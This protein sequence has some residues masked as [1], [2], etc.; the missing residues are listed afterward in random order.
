MGDGILSADSLSLSLCSR[1]GAWLIH[2][3][4]IVLAIV[5]L[6]TIPGMSQDLTWSIVN[7]GYLFV[8]PASSL[9]RCLVVCTLRPLAS[10]N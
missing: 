6:E 7:L 2:V 1:T 10:P 4:L 5:L 9:P 8:R 3:V